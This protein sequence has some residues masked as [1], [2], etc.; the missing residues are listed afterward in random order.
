MEAYAHTHT[1]A[2]PELGDQLKLQLHEAVAELV[3]FNSVLA[4]VFI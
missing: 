4:D 1:Y 3:D 2:Y